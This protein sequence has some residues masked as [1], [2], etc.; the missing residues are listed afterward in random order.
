MLKKGLDAFPSTLSHILV[1]PTMLMIYF[2]EAKKLVE[3]PLKYYYARKNYAKFNI[4]FKKLENDKIQVVNLYVQ[5]VRP[6]ECEK[7]VIIIVKL[8]PYFGKFFAY[9]VGKILRGFPHRCSC[10]L[11]PVFLVLFLSGIV[12]LSVFTQP[13][14]LYSSAHS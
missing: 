7:Y 11:N 3:E 6:Q 14:R 4:S 2:I 13:P 8:M 10:E 5:F 9:F 12:P 1:R